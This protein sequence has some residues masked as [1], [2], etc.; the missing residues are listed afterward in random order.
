MI[1]INNFLPN[2]SMA[3]LQSSWYQR[4]SE[5]TSHGGKLFVSQNLKNEYDNDILENENEV[6]P[7]SKLRIKN[8]NQIFDAREALD[9]AVK[10]PLIRN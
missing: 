3:M 1:M 7:L 2:F 8:H 10:P 6:N 9:R 4:E 5:S